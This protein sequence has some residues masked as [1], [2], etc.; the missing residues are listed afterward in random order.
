MAD[1]LNIAI[2]G[3][4]AHQTA[5]AVTGNNI[6]NAGVEGYSRQEVSFGEGNSQFRGGVWLGSGVSVDSVT[7]I[8]NDFQVERLRAD[9]ADYNHYDTL[10]GYAEQVDSLLADAATGIQPGLENMFDAMQV[11]I[12][13][14]ASL[15]AR[16]VLITQAN[17]LT[18]RFD[19]ISDQLYQQNA[20]V[21]G[22]MQVISQEVNAIAESIASLNQDITFAVG[23]AQGEQ[24]NGLMDQRDR[25]VNQLSELVDVTVVDQ[26]EQ[27][28]VFIGNGQ[29][30]VVGNDYRTLSASDGLGDPTR[31]DLY[32]SSDDEQLTVTSEINGGSLGGLL[33]F[34]SEVLDSV[35]NNM[36]KLSLVIA[37]SFNQQH[38]L[39]V[40]YEGLIG[41]DFFKDINA[42]ASQYAR[43]LGD[44][45]NA[46]PDDRV[47]AIAITD[48]GALGN[49]DYEME[50][51][52][53]DDYTYRIRDLGTQEILQK[54]AISGGFPETIE[55]EGK[56]FEIRLESGSFQAGDSFRIMPT[57]N[58]SVNMEVVIARAEQIA[59]ASPILTQAS[60][61][62][63]GTATVTAGV[64]NDLGT[65]AFNELGQLDPPLVVRFTS[66]TT[67]EVL[68]N[69]DPANPTALFPAIEHQV[70][71]PGIQNRLSLGEEHQLATSSY[72][73][74]IPIRATYQGPAP[75]AEVEATNGFS[76]QHMSVSYTDPETGLTRDYPELKTPANASA[77]EIAA[78]M[79]EYEGITATAN[80]RLELTDFTQDANGFL[81]MTFSLNGVV[82]TDTL[83]EG[84]SKYAPGYPEQV[85][86]P[87]TP[88]FL[89]DRINANYDFQELGIVARS[90]GETLTVTGL[91]GHD[92]SVELTGDG[93][94][95]FQVSNGRDI[96]LTPTGETTF[97][98]LN[99]YEGYDFSVGGPYTYAFNID[100]QGAFEIELSDNYET[101]E[102][103]LSGIK[104]AL[105]T[106]GFAFNGELDIAID[107][108]GD[109]SFQPRLAMNAT[110]VAGSSKLTIG[111]QVKVALDEGVSLSNL[112]AGN[113]LFD[114]EIEWQPTYMGIDVSISGAAQQGD[115][116]HIQFNA[117][118]ISDSR[119]G[120]A[121]NNLQMTDTVSGSSTFSEAYAT[122]VEQV[123]ALTSRAQTSRDSAEVLLATSKESI[124]STS[125][126][127]LDEEAAALIQYEL[128]YNASA[129]VIQVARDMF[130][131]LIATF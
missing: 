76:A 41:E 103:M 107:E 130:D 30:L 123:G 69:S 99:E 34:R 28:N 111:G 48:A 20:V 12:D 35:L 37:E 115:E 108:R 112:K 16:E 5:L 24:P 56:G 73:G 46:N 9:T 50:F 97:T 81:D 40:D 86:D 113:N 14:P 94:D 78:A 57:R 62:N 11:V 52:G 10:A 104:Q 47:L 106:A 102:A 25:L 90:D 23:L 127:N 7:R 6:T 70:Y 72:V 75:A 121:L 100:G 63:R 2:T 45:N 82:L 126:V 93:G 49:S 26:G 1:I 120:V 21:N 91:N 60:L 32:L 42:E 44:R 61:G 110:G 116:F 38:Q 65:S 3:L 95:G 92:L 89:A 98:S 105:E 128:A 109:I 124:T 19:V 51:V 80:S 18:D 114:E 64:V 129:Q 77:L 118:G 29:A 74:Q 13:D 66:D 36:G 122:L 87:I 88:N 43:V 117:E 8:Y 101:A 83:G 53:P 17:A 71:V 4:K 27:Y 79:D 131:T 68:D 33:D 54:G 125:G 119:N 85:P 67:Y 58:E 39:G 55:V 59:L 22:Q 96:Q 31:Y 15:A 84:Q